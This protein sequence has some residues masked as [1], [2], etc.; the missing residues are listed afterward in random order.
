[1]PHGAAETPPVSNETAAPLNTTSTPL[2]YG[3]SGDGAGGTVNLFGKS[4][5]SDREKHKTTWNQ[6]NHTAKK[7]S[8]FNKVGFSSIIVRIT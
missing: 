5:G 8:T 6:A 4:S 7:S 1:V 2:V 3:G